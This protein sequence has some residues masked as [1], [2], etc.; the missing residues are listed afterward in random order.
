MKGVLA[1]KLRAS[2]GTVQVEEGSSAVAKRKITEGVAS[3]G[4]QLVYTS[5]AK[6]FTTQCGLEFLHPPKTVFYLGTSPPTLHLLGAVEKGKWNFRLISIKSQ[7]SDIC[8][9]SG[10][11]K[12]GSRCQESPFC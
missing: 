7:D 11:Q 12:K 6:E 2:K 5:V 9:P 3:P 10:R 8:I 1:V 4:V